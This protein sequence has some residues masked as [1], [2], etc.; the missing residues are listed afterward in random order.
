MSQVLTLEHNFP[1]LASPKI[2]LTWH[3]ADRF[4][5]PK[6]DIS[7]WLWHN[8]DM[9]VILRSGVRLRGPCFRE[10]RRREGR[11]TAR[12]NCRS[13]DVFCDLCRQEKKAR[14]R[15]FRGSVS[16]S[17]SPFPS[18]P[19]LLPSLLFWAWGPSSVDLLSDAPCEVEGRI[20]LEIY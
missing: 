9:L 10:E 5:Q 18:L 11:K 17:P 20:R 3:I 19:P 2:R 6:A 8:S 16:P 7:L 12:G 4:A 13:P 1:C 15:N 14:K